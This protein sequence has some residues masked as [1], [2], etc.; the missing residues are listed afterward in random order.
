M[1]KKC[2][3]IGAIEAQ[4]GFYTR[5]SIPGP[6]YL[7][8]AVAS[9]ASC[10]PQKAASFCIS[11]REPVRLCPEKRLPTTYFGVARSRQR[12]VGAPVTDGLLPLLVGI[13]TGTSFETTLVTPLALIART[14]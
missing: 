4:G 2:P 14:T 9:V 10:A 11:A 13:T 5:L 12:G 7:D 8:Q 1:V 3:E 6:N